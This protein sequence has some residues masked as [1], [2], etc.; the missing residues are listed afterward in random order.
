MQSS[1]HY[2]WTNAVYKRKMINQGKIS[3]TLEENRREAI[4]S[5]FY[6]NYTSKG[7]RKEF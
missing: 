4:D 1:V 3:P 7:T 5:V 2:K 6:N